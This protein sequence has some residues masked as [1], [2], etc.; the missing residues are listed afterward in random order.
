MG[1]DTYGAMPGSSA[2]VEASES[3]VWW[4]REFGTLHADQL[5]G[6]AAVDAGNTPTTV[7]RA[8]LILAVKESDGLL[9]PFDPDSTT[10]GLNVAHAVLDRSISMLNNQ[11][12]AANK[13]GHVLLAGA[14]RGS[15]LLIEGA[16]LIGHTAEHQVRRQLEATGRYFFDTKMRNGA[17]CLGGALAHKAASGATAVGVADNGMMFV[18]SGADTTFTLPTIAEGLVYDFLMASDHEMVIASAEGDNMIVGNDLSADSI[19]FTTAGQQIGARCK[20][21][22]IRIGATLKW[23]TE[24][25]NMPFGTGLTGGFTYAI[26]T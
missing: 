7:L 4:G 23:L 11:G 12:S 25:P 24:L 14:L 15:K 10:A 5:I 16:A 1:L 9:Y 26:A 21:Y 20:V 13:Q 17:A 19:T 18:A 3:Q 22:G 6:S 8:G 2:L